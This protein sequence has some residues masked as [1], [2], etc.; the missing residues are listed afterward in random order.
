M[1]FDYAELRRRIKAVCRTEVKF[2][3]AMGMS[4]SLASMKLNG[5]TK[6]NPCEM[7]RACELLHIP[8]SDI[9]LY[10]FKPKG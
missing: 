5:K 1:E 2:A 6:W 9:P 8:F 4:K 7:A 3:E 10:F